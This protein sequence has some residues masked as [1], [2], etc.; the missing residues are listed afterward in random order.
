MSDGVITVAALFGVVIVAY[1]L[2]RMRLQAAL[3]KCER[4]EGQVDDLRRQIKAAQQECRAVSKELGAI[5]DDRHLRRIQ[6]ALRS[7]G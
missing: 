7:T 4:L 2:Q 1:G 3:S 5:A 6:D